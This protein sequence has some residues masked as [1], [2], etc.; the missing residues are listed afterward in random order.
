M[1]DNIQLDLKTKAYLQSEGL[2]TNFDTAENDK[3]AQLISYLYIAIST[4]ALLTFTSYIGWI[5]TLL[6]TIFTVL[7]VL[8]TFETC[9]K[10]GNSDNKKA[11]FYWSIRDTASKAEKYN[12]LPLSIQHQNFIAIGIIFICGL[13]PLAL[14]LAVTTLI[15][16]SLG[17]SVKFAAERV[18]KKA[19][20][21][22]VDTN[23]NA[24]QSAVMN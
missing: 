8:G 24:G 4:L 13:W 14:I 20:S 10:L 5:F 22:D 19:A 1:S 2:D 16:S 3:K 18:A 23:D 21:Y 9:K 11:L 12:F 15:S 17:K 7:C 6:L